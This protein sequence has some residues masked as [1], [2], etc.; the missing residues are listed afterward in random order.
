VTC[1][2]VRHFDLGGPSPT[3]V[4][5]LRAKGRVPGAGTRAAIDAGRLTDRVVAEK[6]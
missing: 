1:E 5:E 3:L 6:G 2:R 4:V